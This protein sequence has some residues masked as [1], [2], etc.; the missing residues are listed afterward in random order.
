MRAVLALLLLVGPASALSPS[1]P[2]SLSLL[3]QETDFFEKKIRPI[4]AERCYSCHSASAKTLQ[5]EL[6]L[7]TRDGVT[8]VAGKIVAAVRH[9]GDLK[10]PPKSKL[11]DEQIADI[12]TW[13]KSGAPMPPD[14]SPQKKEAHWAFAPPKE[15]E[16]PAGKNPV[17]FF[18]E[19]AL[20]AKGLTLA[21]GADRRTLVRRLTFDLTGLPPAPAEIDAFVADG[22][23]EKLVD[24]LLASSRYGERW[25]RHWLDVARYSD[26]K[27]YVFEEERRFANAWTYRD[28]VVK[29]FND[30]LP[31]DQFLVA[32]IAADR[33][34]AEP[35]QLAA[36][37]FLTVGRRFLN[38]IHDIIDDRIDVVTRG[39]MGLTLGCAR[40]H[41]HKYDPL[42]Q[43]DYY[44]LYGVFAASPEAQNPPPIPGP[45]TREQR[46]AFVAE[47]TKREEE[48][49]A[50]KKRRF[51]AILKELDKK[52]EA[53]IAAAKEKPKDP[54]A[55]ALDR[56]LNPLVLKR[57]IAA[58]KKEGDPV[59]PAFELKEVDALLSDDDK[60]KLKE[61]QRGI[62]EVR[63]SHPGAPAKPMCLEE[64]GVHGNPRVFLRGNPGRPGPEVP[65]RFPEI[66]GGQL[67]KSGS[68][69]LEL[70]KAIASRD[71]PLTAR[72]WVNR[73]W[74]HHFGAGLVRTP[75]DFGT[76][77]DPPTHPELLDA[78]ALR[79]MADGWS[80]KK[81]HKRIVLSA[82]YLQSGADNGK[83]R[84][85]DPENRLLWR[86]PLRRLDFEELR[87]SLLFASG[88]LDFALG[89]KPVGL[90]GNRRTIY[91]TIERQNLP[92]LFRVFDFA[93][94]DTTSPQRFTTTVPQ[95]ALYLMN[96]P[97]VID[98]ARALGARTTDLGELWRLTL[99]RP[100]TEAERAAAT[101]YLAAEPAGEVLP[102]TWSYG[103]GD[104]NAEKKTVSFVALPHFTGASWQGGPQLPDKSLGWVVL[105][106]AGGH[107]GRKHAVIR[108]W[109]AP[110]DGT[111][112]ITGT[113]HH[114]SDKGDGVVARIVI[115]GEQ[116]ATAVAK[117][118]QA[119]VTARAGVKKGDTIDF[120]V[121][122]GAN[123]SYDSFEW[124]PTI[125]MGGQT[126]SASTEFS[127]PRPPPL[128][129]WEKLAQILIMTNEFSYVD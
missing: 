40:C 95:Q 68:G 58:L 114:P 116:I 106:A 87:D 103:C 110:Q 47:L 83:A 61:F 86:F 33:L 14:T 23:V 100:P 89:G 119:P 44:A 105:G 17:D 62:D 41:D 128:T 104:F 79:F 36:M 22:D 73:V 72:V 19:R 85:V 25:G 34:N 82:P 111:V 15:V 32:Q 2:L 3:P 6:R 16:V 49:A 69:R 122:C 88:R 96:S 93:S 80:T 75:S 97:F 52:R 77:S 127:G 13:V 30:D 43:K 118:K 5:G 78:L 90:D 125:T 31:Y 123:E 63:I 102:T 9:E 4:F 8:R 99:G 84:A 124:A 107:P 57:W 67:F 121:E 37:G 98:A 113:L 51:D 53:Y 12:E 81:L 55:F 108:R 18:I 109:T 91:V 92:A 115:H 94:P 120:I 46:D 11:A 117:Q 10:M 126:W 112:E 26:T 7:D 21:P 45:Q 76:R 54:D 42:T 74:L 20:A 101:K 65:R 48:I 24:R 70:A 71:N 129:P 29:A 38:D 1:L 50:F 56:K 27:G 39:A 59:P 28:W 60:N 66:L 64:G 35:S